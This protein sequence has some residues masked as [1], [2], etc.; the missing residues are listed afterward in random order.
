MLNLGSGLKSKIIVLAIVISTIAVT[1]IS[2]ISVIYS[3][4]A[5]KNQIESQLMSQ[6]QTV[7]TTITGHANK[8][9]IYMN[10]IADNRMIEGIFIA[11]EGTFMEWAMP[12]EKIFQII[13]LH[14]TK[15]QRI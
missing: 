11:F 2:V 10:Q 12:P 5:L 3:R 15:P 13:K 8:L 7:L 1:S 14:L 6:G 9:R 4:S